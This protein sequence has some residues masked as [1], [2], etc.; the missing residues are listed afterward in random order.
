VDV[1]VVLLLGRAEH[2]AEREAE[3]ERPDV[4]V[5]PH[6]ASSLAGAASS[7]RFPGWEGIQPGISD[8]GESGGARAG[9]RRLS[10]PDRHRVR[11]WAHADNRHSS[12]L[13]GAAYSD[14]T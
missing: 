4:G 12:A 11:R 5:V 9:S 14:L 6:I 2:R 1:P 7:G 8:Q 10:P 3:R 13:I